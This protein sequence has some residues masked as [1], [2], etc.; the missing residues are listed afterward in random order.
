M[1]LNLDVIGSEWET[2]ERSWD[3]KDGL[4][5]AL[6]VGAGSDRATM[7]ADLPFVTENSASVVQRMLPTMAVVLATAEGGPSFGTYHLSQVLHAEQSVH[8]HGEIPVK[9][10]GRVA[11]RVIDILDKGRDALIIIESSLVD[12]STGLRIATAQSTIF[13]RGEG[14]FG[15]H[16]GASASWQRPDVVADRQ[17]A[18]NTSVQQALV[19]R[20]S[21]DRNPL[22]SD[23]QFASEAGFEQ[24]ILHGLCT[25][26]IAGRALL[27]SVADSDPAR[28]G[29]LSARFASPVTPGDRLAIHIWKSDG[30]A[31][32]QAKVGE[33]LV[34]DRGVFTLR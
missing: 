25:F 5:Y 20:L 2:G 34:L 4:I 22:H 27:H 3:S 28:F 26:G 17:I 8:L 6:G 15:G 12:V 23:P 32:F 13:V 7:A 14:G 33:R 30:G 24:P 1:T 19:Y 16:R 9:G 18:S 11:S 29:S 31:V 10:T 21:G